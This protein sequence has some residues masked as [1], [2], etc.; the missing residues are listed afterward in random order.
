MAT[1]S[2]FNRFVSP[3]VGNCPDVMVEFNARN[4][5]IDFCRFTRIW[6]E[7]LTAID[8]VANVPAYSPAPPTDSEF[9]RFERISYLT[10]QLIPKTQDQLDAIYPNGWALLTGTPV[11][12]T[13]T[14]TGTL[15]LVPAPAAT[16]VGAITIR[17]SLM[18]S[19]IGTTFPDLIFKRY[20]VQIAAG[21]KSAILG[22]VGVP[23]SNPQ[24]AAILFDDYQ[25][26]RANAMDFEARGLWR[27][28]LRT[29]GNFF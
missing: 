14:N 23:W 9:V 22:M 27:A 13:A 3:E 26:G 15:T 18:P 8:S 2:D 11:Y 21:I 4:T 6:Q 10:T 25:V 1:L 5:L 20:S 16:T 12:Y 28:R 24:A 29:A 7:E 17:A 19:Q